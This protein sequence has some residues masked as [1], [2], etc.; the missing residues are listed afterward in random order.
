MSL[1]TQSWGT[2]LKKDIE[3]IVEGR[4]SPQET[5]TSNH[6][7]KMTTFYWQI[8][9]METEIQLSL[10]PS[11]DVT[12]YDQF[13]FQVTTENI[14]VYLLF[15]CIPQFE[16]ICLLSKMPLLNSNNMNDLLLNWPILL[17][18]GYLLSFYVLPKLILK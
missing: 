18:M 9:T 4:I 8:S 13:L 16:R 10:S 17:C 11:Q 12:R 3:I 15:C 7:P 5:S 14:G 1:V 2:D 6:N